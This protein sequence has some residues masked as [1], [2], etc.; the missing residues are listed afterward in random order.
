MLTMTRD[1]AGVLDAMRRQE[2]I[3]DPFVVR[4]FPKPTTE[5]S[6]VQ[7][8]FAS[9]PAPGDQVTATEGT[10]LC[11]DQ[12]LAEPLANAVIDAQETPAGPELV[13]RRDESA[14][15][16]DPQTNGHNPGGLG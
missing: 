14:Q 7:I 13:L 15:P 16:G 5:G 6:E 12:E 3:P 1:A 9:E 4:V 8:S 11:V 2:G 10:T